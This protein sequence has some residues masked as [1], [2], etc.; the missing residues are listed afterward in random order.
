[1]GSLT[2]CIKRAGKALSDADRR[3][4]LSR[5][6]AFVKDGMP[7]S[8]AAEMAVTEVHGEIMDQ[9]R[10]AADLARAKGVEV[11]ITG[12]NLTQ[13]EAAPA[14]NSTGGWTP[15]AVSV[16]VAAIENDAEPEMNPL[17]PLVS[18]PD[19]VIVMVADPEIDP[20]GGGWLGPSQLLASQLPAVQ[21]PP[22]QRVLMS[23]RTSRPS[24]C[25][26]RRQCRSRG[27]WYR[28]G[29]GTPASRGRPTTCRRSR[30]R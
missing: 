1:M 20:G 2:S 17:A 25:R 27:P 24:G 21:L 14:G 15:V 23:R 18:V 12:G 5:Y 3:A 26:P 28:R 7:A 13:P 22:R 16:P 4:L 11:T 10:E 8:D 9:V 30:R 6:D 19:R 29:R